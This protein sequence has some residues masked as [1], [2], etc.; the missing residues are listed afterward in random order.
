MSEKKIVI[1][2]FDGPEKFVDITFKERDNVQTTSGCRH[3][4]LN[5]I[6]Q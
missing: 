2:K 1:D 6:Q 4:E 5:N 3:Y